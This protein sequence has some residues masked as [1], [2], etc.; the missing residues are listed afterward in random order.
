MSALSDSS[1]YVADLHAPEVGAATGD[2]EA[3]LE[4]KQACVGY[5]KLQVVD[6]VSL[7]LAEGEFLSLIG[8][9]GAGKTT[10]MAA[11][12]GQLPLTAGT[13]FYSGR[14]VTHWREDRRAR[15][16]IGRSYQKTHL[17]PHLSALANVQLAVQARRGISLLHLLQRVP[18]IVVEEA[19]LGLQQVGLQTYANT[20]AAELAHG[21]K[22]KLELAMLLA[23]RPRVMLLDE[24]TAGMSLGEAT[25]V[26]ELVTQLKNSGQYGMILVEHK[27]EVVLKM[28][29][30]VMVLHQGRQ[31][32]VGSPDEVMANPAV[33][34]AYLGGY[35]GKLA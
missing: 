29:H 15:A 24:P 25:E 17:F 7:T 6:G 28:S 27:L 16:G 23:L 34:K 3:L 26:L 11:M 5:G 30:R 14:D 20:V 18:R 1:Q 21:D 22:R 13:L 33:E 31:L 32:A 10:L 2:R 9:N 12:A 4:L 8:P 35:H 19:E